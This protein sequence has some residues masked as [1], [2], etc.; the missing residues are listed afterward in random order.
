M[1]KLVILFI[2]PIFFGFKTGDEFDEKKMQRDLE[3]AKDILAT[4]IKSGSDSFF[5]STSIDAS[6]IKDYG[7]V[8]TI[9]EHLV[10]FHP[11]GNLM[12]IPEIPPI[13]D[14]DVDFD[15]NGEFEFSDEDFF[16]AEKEL[17]KQ[18]KLKEKQ[19]K[20]MQKQQYKMQQQME[21]MDIAREEMQRARDEA[22]A[23][24]AEER[25]LRQFYVSGGDAEAINWEEIMITFMTDY[26]DLIAQLQPE[27]R[28]VIKQ[29]SPYNQFVIVMSDGKT[30]EKLEQNGSNISAEVMRKDISAYKSGKIKKDEF[31]KR[32]S[33]EKKSP[34]RKIPDLEMFA[35]IFDRFYSHDLS[36]SFY[37]RG[38]PRYEVLEGFGAVFYIEAAS[39]NGRSW[40]RSR[41]RDYTV[42]TPSDEDTAKEEALYPKFKEDLKAFLLDYGRTIRS[43]DDNEKVML[44][45]ELSSCRECDVPESMEVSVKMS[46]LKQY[47]QQKLSREKAMDQIVIKEK[48]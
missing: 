22:R 17:K 16:K 36:E 15:F 23:A 21:E 13:P 38:K 28:I 46:T 24:I 33:I 30:G 6:Y 1:K 10:Y 48:A 4:L 42:A 12:V 35:S 5:G 39:G 3:I 34:P 31:I 8:F 37:S 43:L 14:V 40:T 19:E 45:I 9:P 44:N 18:Q 27:D 7:V 25:E 26:A 41:Y 32:I 11:G 47:D 20:E 29:K 2:I